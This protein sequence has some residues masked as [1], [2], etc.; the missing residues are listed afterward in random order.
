MVQETGVKLEGLYV[1]E[2]IIKY[3]RQNRTK[4]P[5]PLAKDEKR[6]NRRKC[7]E[8]MELEKQRLREERN[9]IGF[10]VDPNAKYPKGSWEEY[11]QQV[12]VRKRRIEMEELQER[13]EEA[14]M[15]AI[16]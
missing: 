8:E 1:K 16:K 2:T 3:W 9:H 13:A 12:R 4:Y 6:E 5:R 15:E 10:V 14:Q 11:L 7:Q